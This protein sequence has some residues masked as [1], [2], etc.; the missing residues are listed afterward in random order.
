MKKATPNLPASSRMQMPSGGSS[1]K[2]MVKDKA[3]NMAGKSGAAIKAGGVAKKM[4]DKAKGKGMAK[5]MY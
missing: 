3:K 2:G 1:L 5:K 4:V